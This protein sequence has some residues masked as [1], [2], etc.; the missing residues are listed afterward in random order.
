MLPE[1]VGSRIVERMGK[2]TGNDFRCAS[3]LRSDTSDRLQ[4]QVA[5]KMMLSRVAVLTLLWF[6]SVQ[7]A[8]AEPAEWDQRILR[9]A[10]DNP[11]AGLVA[12]EVKFFEDG[13]TTPKFCTRIRVSALS[14]QEKTVSFVVQQMAG[15]FARD[16]ENSTFGGWAVLT[17]GVYTITF[18]QCGDYQYF[19]GP[20][21]RFFVNRGQ[22]LNLGSLVI[23]YKNAEFKLLVPGRP[24]GDWKVE[25]LS[26][27]A[28]ATLKKKSPTAFSKA[29]KQ[30]MI[31][32]R[33]TKPAP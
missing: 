6:A 32:V 26:P 18:I 27:A 21:A 22:V 1:D 30:Y 5:R 13:N 24:T 3:P 7:I 8:S 31:P 2:T 23:R 10:N 11:N 29:S 16:I 12:M 19:R 28:V 15:F 17:P 9:L 14:Q 25:D 33:L 20:F 4:A